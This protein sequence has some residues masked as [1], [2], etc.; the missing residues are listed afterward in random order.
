[1]SPSC[2]AVRTPLRVWKRRIASLLM[3]LVQIACADPSVAWPQRSTS[4]VGVNQ[5][6]PQ[7]SSARVRNAV[8]ARFISAATFAI[9]WS[10]RAPSM[11]RTAA[12]LPLNASLVKAS[13]WRSF[14]SETLHR[15]RLG[16]HPAD[17]QEA[18]DDDG[19]QAAVA[20]ERVGAVDGRIVIADHDEDQRHGHVGVLAR[21]KAGL[22]HGLGVGR[23]L[24]AFHA[25]DDLL[26]IRP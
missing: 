10:S 2:F 5:R 17:E 16:V 19:R 21:T 7:P 4:T 6:S 24:I 8:S 1:M 15:R 20:N 3:F 22:A 26:L 25:L 11:K 9:H 18:E 13:I 23:G 12:G 14:N